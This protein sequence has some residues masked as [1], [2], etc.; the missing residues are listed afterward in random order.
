[1]IIVFAPNA[2]KQTLIAIII[3]HPIT[4]ALRMHAKSIMMRAVLFAYSMEYKWM[5]YKCM[6]LCI[7]SVAQKLCNRFEPGK[8]QTNRSVKCYIHACDYTVLETEVILKFQGEFST[9]TYFNTSC[10]S[11]CNQYIP[12]LNQSE[13]EKERGKGWEGNRGG[14]TVVPKSIPTG[15]RTRVRHVD[16]VGGAMGVAPSGV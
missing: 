10:S 5:P 2:F 7:T 16:K 11:T 6:G 13:C 1:M 8:H 9:Q 12:K 15:L 3:I 14:K 4:N